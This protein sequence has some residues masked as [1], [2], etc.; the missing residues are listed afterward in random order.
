MASLLGKFCLK[1]NDF[2]TNIRSSYKDLRET[3]DFSDVTLISEDNQQVEAHRIILSACSPFFMDWLKRSKHSHP[4]IYMRGIQS[5]DLTAIMDFIYHGEANVFEDDLEHFLSLAEELKLRGL[6]GGDGK[7]EQP[8]TDIQDDKRVVDSFPKTKSQDTNETIKVKIDVSE[9]SSDM[10]PF[11]EERISVQNNSLVSIE[12]SNEL[13]E[14]INSM[15]EIAI[16][17]KE[18]SCIVCGKMA[19]YKNNIRQHIE[20]KH[21]EG[22]SHTCNLCGKI[23]R[24]RNGLAIHVLKHHKRS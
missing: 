3:I 5:R 8:V 7:H 19:S 1:W 16:G 4:I 14:K 6:T 23:S 2:Q 18:W 13:D 20:A 21:I 24:S 9:I 17:S 12:N 22:V 15:M 10:L 11:D